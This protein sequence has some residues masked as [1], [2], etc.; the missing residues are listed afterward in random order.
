MK[1]TLS[2]LTAL[3]L[4]SQLVR[5]A[6]NLVRE[7]SGQN[8]F[9]GWD[10]YGSYDNL[11]NGDVVWVNQSLA[12]TDQ[13]AFVNG[14]GNAIIKVDNTSFV[15]YN[16]KRDSVRITTEDYFPV[17]SVFIIDAA[18]L[19][20]GCS[21]WPSFWTKGPN[22]P[23]GGEID[24]IE[25]VNQMTFNQMALHTQDGCT[26][27]PP[28]DQISSTTL[29]NCSAVAGCTVAEKQPN[30]FGAGFASAGGGV[31]ATQFDESGIYIWFWTRS[32]VPSS[33]NSSTT[34]VD[35][36]TWGAPTAGYPASTCNI[37]NFFTE[38]QLVLDITLCGDWAGEASVYQ[39]TC[40]GSTPAN[41]S[42]C[43]LD[44]VINN[45][46]SAYAN[47]YFEI[48]YIKAFNVDGTIVG[49]S[50]TASVSPASATAEPPAG[51]SSASSSSG[52]SGS[53]SN[54]A[55]GSNGAAAAWGAVLVPTV[56]ALAVGVSA[57]LA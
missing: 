51:S 26:A 12:T 56:L 7:Y 31:W 2:A 15:P 35:P 28:S 36:S 1:Y 41:A 21:V 13:L 54:T 40:P 33:I 39:D 10:Y 6:Y 30:S 53:G 25:G 11:T 50:G 38:Q 34:S 17:G 5:G 55:A 48:S 29:T 32:S 3:S 20:Y 49:P 42:S 37:T 8:F 43:Y 46:T 24:I 44:N 47:A 9:T 45:G 14:A 19:P 16:D 52:S 23:I 22:W 57:L 4:Q 18:H 27:S